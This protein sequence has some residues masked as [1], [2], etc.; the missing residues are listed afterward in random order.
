MISK[1]RNDYGE[2][3]EEIEVECIDGVTI[4]HEAC[5]LVVNWW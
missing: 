2:T 5:M 4:D 3:V 1:V